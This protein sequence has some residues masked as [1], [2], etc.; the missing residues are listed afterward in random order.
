MISGYGISTTNIFSRLVESTNTS[1][2]QVNKGKLHIAKNRKRILFSNFFYYTSF[3]SR[4]FQIDIFL[5]TL[6]KKKDKY[7]SGEKPLHERNF[8]IIY[9]KIY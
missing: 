9:R 3:L 6:I 8:F 2:Y 7:K 1:S 5:N 4:L